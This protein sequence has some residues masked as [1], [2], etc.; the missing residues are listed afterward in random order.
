M[1]YS[2]GE[3]YD[4]LNSLSTYDK[5]YFIDRAEIKDGMMKMYPVKEL[6]ANY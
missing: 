5:V 6:K 1:R 4:F 3:F 2:S